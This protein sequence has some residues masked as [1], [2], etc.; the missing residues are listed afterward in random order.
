MD[1]VDFLAA[2]SGAAR[3]DLP[4]GAKLATVDPAYALGAGWPA[5][6][7][8]PKVTFDGEST[9]STKQYPIVAGYVPAASDR[10]VLV[11]VGRTYVIVGRL[12]PGSVGRPDGEWNASGN[13]TIGNGSETLVAFGT[14]TTATPLVTRA[15]DGVGHKFTLAAGAAGLWAGAATTRWAAGT[16]GQ[17]FTAI[18]VDGASVGA[19]TGGPGTTTADTHVTFLRRLA[20]GAV[21]RVSVYQ[22]N[23]GNLALTALASD[24]WVRLNLARVGP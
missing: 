1:A 22:T 5:T 20:A 2:V 7:A 6:P 15:T 12:L 4:P 11:P 3:A 16:G 13:Q 23:G 14:E 10:V 8:L 21:I 18:T 24:A 19:N 17:R 9:M